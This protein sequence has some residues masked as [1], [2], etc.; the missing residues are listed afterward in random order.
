MTGRLN[1]LSFEL[2]L[3]CITCLFY[4]IL[5]K[6]NNKSIKCLPVLK[7]NRNPPCIVEY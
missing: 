4:W 2:G 1:S 3:V 5:G 6:L 7:G